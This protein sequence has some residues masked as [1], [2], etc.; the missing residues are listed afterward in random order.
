MYIYVC[1]YGMHGMY[2]TLIL[3]NDVV[4]DVLPSCRMF[5]VLSAI[6]QLGNVAIE[7]VSA[8]MQCIPHVLHGMQVL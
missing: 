5:T 3:D 6:L 4:C 8:Y 2:T 7:K 1:V